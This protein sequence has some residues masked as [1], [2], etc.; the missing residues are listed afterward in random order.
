[1]IKYIVDESKTSGLSERKLIGHESTIG[2][3]DIIKEALKFLPNELDY[4]DW[5]K[6]CAAIKGAF[7]GD[8]CYYPEFEEW[9]CLKYGGDNTPEKIRGVWDSITDT[10]LGANYVLAMARNAG[11]LSMRQSLTR[12]QTKKWAI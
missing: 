2:D 12:S 1:M 4:D 5:I 8:E 10:T 9:C 6:M 3:P 7:G 11:F